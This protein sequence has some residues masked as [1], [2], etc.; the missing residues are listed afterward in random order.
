MA[1]DVRLEHDRT[2][3]N[4]LPQHFKLDGRAGFRRPQKSVCSR[5]EAHVHIVTGA[6]QEHQPDRRRASGA[7]GGRG[8][9][10]R[11]GGSGLRRMLP[12]ARARGV[13]VLDMGIHSTDLVVY[14]GDA[15]LLP[16]AFRFGAIISPG[17]SHD[18]KSPTKTPNA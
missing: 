10:V 16:L 5:L 9:H 15:M 13:A 3:L 14:D 17:M 8:D 11:T 4:V 1:A 12:E 7:P 6:A 18:S 2:L